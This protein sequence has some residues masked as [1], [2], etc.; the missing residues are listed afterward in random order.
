MSIS[1]QTL[2]AVIVTFKSE[3]VIHDCIKSIPKDIKIIIVDNS[4]DEK[5][6]ENLEKKYSNIT[7][8]LSPRNLGMGA[9]N[10]LGLRN[11]K[12]DFA[13]ILNPDIV[14]Q[15][16]SIE[17]I[18]NCSKKIDSYSILAPLS[19]NEK[20]P[21][22]KVYK[23]HLANFEN[24]FKVKSV[25]GFAML[26]NLKRIN[27][28]E[29]FKDFNYFDSNIFM[30]LEN[31]DLCKRLNENNENIFIVPK[32]KIKHLGAKAVDQIYSH[33]IELSRNWHWIW[34][35]FYFNKKH[36]GFFYAFLKGLPGF[37]SAVLKLVIYSLIN[38]KEKKEIYQKRVF[39]FIKAL[40]GKS[41]SYRPN[42]KI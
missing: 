3:K 14:L 29:S 36:Y 7:C 16:D 27:Q 1:R 34:S 39:G 12:T 37:L 32:S 30:Y 13:I 19:I 41:S 24:P 38:K 23:E 35:K 28:I 10:N 31:D 25:D 22:Y 40:Q 6:K 26:L 11:V 2:T 20:Y 18:I 4:N 42:I 9:G 5:F 8:I 33:E 21:N 15:E 17:E